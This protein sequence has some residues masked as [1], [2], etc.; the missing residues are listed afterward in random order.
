M[1]SATYRLKTSSVA[2]AT[3]LLLILPPVGE[4]YAADLSPES[5]CEFKPLAEASKAI[6]EALASRIYIPAA[7]E[8]VFSLM[9][10]V[11]TLLLNESKLL[12][13]DFAMVVDKEFWNLLQ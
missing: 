2:T 13:R 10:E 6:S 4:M 3:A 7:P 8:T 5:F 1:T 9:T 12:D 11:A